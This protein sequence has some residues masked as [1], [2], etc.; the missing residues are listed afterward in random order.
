MTLFVVTAILCV[1]IVLWMAGGIQSPKTLTDPPRSSSSANAGAPTAADTNTNT[2]TNT[3]TSTDADAERR[4]I[5]TWNIAWGYGWGSEGSGGR[6]EPE[7]FA[8]SIEAMAAFLRSV[9]ADIVL[10]Q[11]VD[12]DSTRSGHVDQLA[13]LSEKT[14]LMY[15]A[16]AV[17][18]QA[19]WVP[20]PYWPPSNHFGAMS[21]GGAV[22][23]RYPITSNEVTLLPKP[24]KNPFWYN[25]FYLFRYVQRVE[26][27]SG[28]HT[29]RIYNAH[30][31]AF[32]L[33]NRERQAVV[34]SER[35]RKESMG[36]TILGGDFNS[37]PPEATVRSGYPDEPETNHEADTTIA[38]LRQAGLNDT[39]PETLGG[40]GHHPSDEE[41]YFTFPSHQP[42]RKLDYVLASP[43]FEVVSA[44]VGREAGKVSDHLPL[45]VELRLRPL[46]PPHT[47]TPPQS[48]GDAASHGTRVP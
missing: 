2:N 46:T 29:I 21:S 11:E 34:L 18:W 12:F 14:G 36:Y 48:R 44:R 47:G 13:S 33:G 22:L 28:Q 31:E 16:R 40:P 3:N 42:N 25:L 37:V 30:L 24:A 20:F 32:D 19:N 8:R 5:V 26:V 10:L 41:A 7:H 39:M 17:S 45:V 35:V 23:S 4:T 27:S 6:L 15:S 9:N 1:G 43:S 38:T